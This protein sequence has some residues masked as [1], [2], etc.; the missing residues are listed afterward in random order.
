M[1][2]LQHLQVLK[3]YIAPEYR[4]GMSCARA[5]LQCCSPWGCM[6]KTTG[7]VCSLWSDPGALSSGAAPCAGARG[8]RI[9]SSSQTRQAGTDIFSPLCLCQ[10]AGERE[11][12]WVVLKFSVRPKA[13]VL[14]SDVRYGKLRMLR[15]V[16]NSALFEFCPIFSNVQV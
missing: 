2:R 13:D 8:Q 6:L 11:P 12:D 5:R 3:K 14:P 4:C 1:V 15:V 10:Y 9:I 16:L 7:R